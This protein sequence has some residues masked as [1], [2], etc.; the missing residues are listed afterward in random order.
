VTGDNLQKD[1]WEWRR[2]Y[3]VLSEFTL[4]AL[5]YLRQGVLSY[6]ALIIRFIR[7]IKP[8]F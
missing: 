8:T 6:P 4:E 5:K 3:G 7:S 2:Q 1:C